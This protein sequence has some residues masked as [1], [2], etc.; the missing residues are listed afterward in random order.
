MT[1]RI[2]DAVFGNTY[3]LALKVLSERRG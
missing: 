2:D 3:T 1:I